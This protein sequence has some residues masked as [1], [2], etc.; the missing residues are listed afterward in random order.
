MK[1]TSFSALLASAA[2]AVAVPAHASFSSA[3]GTPPGSSQANP[4]YPTFSQWSS[5]SGVPYYYAQF[6]APTSNEWYSTTIESGGLWRSGIQS[7]Q[8]LLTGGGSFTSITAPEGF[9]VMTLK[10]GNSVVL[11]DFM[12]GQVASFGSGIS[13]LTL[14]LNS[15]PAFTP[16]SSAANSFQVKLGVTG[17]PSTMIWSMNGVA[18]VPETSTFALT[19]FGMLGLGVLTLGS[20]RKPRSNA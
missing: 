4:I 20:K 17:L 11:T 7:A 16:G 1:L 8:L 12:P 10:V 18:A 15:P 14:S 3:S 5:A 2:I 19:V 6:A 9:G 13:W